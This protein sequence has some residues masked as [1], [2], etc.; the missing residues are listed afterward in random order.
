MNFARIN[1]DLK[2][3]DLNGFTKENDYA[4]YYRIIS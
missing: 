2:M 1:N 3:M 4:N